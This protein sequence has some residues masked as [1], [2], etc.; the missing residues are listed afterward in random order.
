MPPIVH[1]M[2]R[3]AWR[4]LFAAVLL[5]TSAVAASVPHTHESLSDLARGTQAAGTSLEAIGKCDAAAAKV[6]LHAA[7]SVQHEHCAACARQHHQGN[8]L[9]ASRA[10]LVTAGRVSIRPLFLASSSAYVALAL[11]RG[12]PT[13]A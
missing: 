12:P 4:K 3:T 1:A 7:R 8:V 10:G 2:R 11:L 5:L 9:V 6:H 13:V